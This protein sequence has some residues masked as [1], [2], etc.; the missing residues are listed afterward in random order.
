MIVDEAHT[1]TDASGGRGTR[2][3]R[4]RLVRDLSANRDRHMILV[5]ATPHSGK[6]D[7]F[8]ELL[9]FLDPS[10]KRFATSTDDRDRTELA[11]HFVQRRRGDIRAY[12]DTETRF[13]T[14]DQPI[15][16][17]YNLTPAYRKLLERVL[18]YARETVRVEGEG[19]QRQRIRWW[20]ALALLRSVSSS[21]QAAMETL[22]NRA[23][24]AES[25]SAEEIEELGRA[26]SST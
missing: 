8:R 26:R 3:Q 19:A 14:R 1:C 25:V 4:Y 21:P 23:Q 20:A 16:A 12:L 5:T 17:I 18:A 6:D 24:F 7:A 11:K 15:D 9:G 13:P 22:R 2:H 10:F